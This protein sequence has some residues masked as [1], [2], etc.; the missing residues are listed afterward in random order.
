[1]IRRAPNPI[2][3]K[4]GTTVMFYS[5]S[6]KNK[7]LKCIYIYLIGWHCVIFFCLL[8]RQFFTR[9]LAKSNGSIDMNVNYGERVGFVEGF[10]KKLF[11]WRKFI[12]HF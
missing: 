11:V 9:Y 7:F 6:C 5:F 4:L 10:R 1:M 8:T 12:N 2:M 3:V